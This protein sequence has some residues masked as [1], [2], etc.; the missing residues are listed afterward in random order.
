MGSRGTKRPVYTPTGT[1][2]TFEWPMGIS[3]GQRDYM[4]RLARESCAEESE[5][6]VGACAIRWL[7]SNVWKR[8]RKGGEA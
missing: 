4:T 8:L 3:R 2:L 1:S 5:A 6:N 7:Q